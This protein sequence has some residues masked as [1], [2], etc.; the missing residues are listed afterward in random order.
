RLILGLYYSTKSG[1]PFPLPVIN[2]HREFAPD[3]SYSVGVPKSNLK[4]YLN[5]KSEF[6]VFA[7]LDGFYANIQEDRSFV[8]SDEVAE[9][10]SMT[11]VLAGLG[12]EFNFTDHLVYY[13]YAGHTLMNDIRLRNSEKD[14]IYS[15]NK[16]NSFY[17]RTGLKFVIF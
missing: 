15:I 4:Y 1:K 10:I 17:G 8:N 16:T 3:W 5:D 2:Y 6:Q 12:Y 7:T 14:D 9:S 11:I 13:I